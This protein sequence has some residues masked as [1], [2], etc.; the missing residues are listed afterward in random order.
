[1]V[2]G[3]GFIICSNIIK[4]LGDRDT[5]E[6]QELQKGVKVKVYQDIR[7]K[8]YQDKRIPGYQ[9]ERIPGYTQQD[10]YKPYKAT[11]NPCWDTKVSRHLGVSK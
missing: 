9:D 2:L 3:K 11:P 1:M 6:I 7:I 4:D 5:S 8:G 10:H